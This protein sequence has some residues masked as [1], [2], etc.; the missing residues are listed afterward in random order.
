MFAD[1]WGFTAVSAKMPGKEVIGLLREYLGLAERA[2]FAHGGTLDKFLGDGL[3]ATF[4]T[5]EPG[6]RD[7]ANALACARTMA[8]AVVK[9]NKR[10]KA[11]GLVPLRIG[12]GMHHG[13]VAVGEV[14]SERRMEFAVIGDTVNIAARIQEMTRELDVALLASDSVIRA[15]GEEAASG[16]RDLGDHAIR[17]RGGSIRLWGRAAE[18]PE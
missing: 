10:R 15:A 2:V 3:M 11:R 8:D 9:W 5:P 7:A 14:G 13:E 12:V 6:P 4:G 18:Q 17:G 1:V 16:F